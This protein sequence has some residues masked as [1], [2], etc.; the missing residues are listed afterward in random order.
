MKTDNHLKAEILRLHHAEH[1]PIGTIAS[2]LRMHHSTVARVIE[3]EGQEPVF[4]QR[5]RK[6]D[7]FLP[8]IEEQLV[9]YPQLTASRLYSMVQERGYTG[10]VAQFR[11]I[12]AGLR[13]PRKT[14]AFQRLSTLS[15]EQAQVDWGHFGHIEIGHASRPLMAFVIVLSYSRAIFIRFFLS[16]NLS[17][18]MHGHQLAFEYFEGVARVCLY[19]N[20]KSVVLERV[21]KTIRFNPQF[22][23]FAGYYRY[24]PR[25]VGVAR[26]NEKGR[27][28]RSIRYIRENFFAARRFK[29]LADLNNQALHW[30]QNTALARRWPEN[31][32]RTVGEV[33]SEEKS[34]LLPLPADIYPCDERC[35]V[36]LSKYPY[37]RF[38]WN[39]YSVPPQFVKKALVVIASLDTVRILDSTQ[40]IATHP[41]S[42][43]RGRRVEQ[44]EHLTTLREIKAAAGQHSRTSLLTNAAPSSEQLLNQ[45]AKRGLPL[46]RIT[47]ELH[48]LLSTYGAAALETAI[49][50]ALDHNTPHAQAVRQVLERDQHNAAKPVALPLQLPDDPRLRNITLSTRSLVDYDKLQEDEDDQ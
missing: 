24:E 27:V 23:S 34:L 29:D 41:R 13:G 6:V 44:P 33:F 49:R 36:V 37:A 15:G 31:Q 20:L 19:D 3:Q 17:N 10:Q 8:F 12:I 45:I 18:F 26:G 4:R 32:K 43:D 35:D 40:V 46:G 7:G 42:Y 9:R 39:D 22:M 47:Q 11:A 25:P 1:W 5:K 2:Q 28:E 21:G 16:Q 30:C 48:E 38:D 14:E 50:E